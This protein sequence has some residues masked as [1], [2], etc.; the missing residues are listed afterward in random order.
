MGTNLP[1]PTRGVRDVVSAFADEVEGSLENISIFGVHMTRKVTLSIFGLFAIVCISIGVALGVD[2]SSSNSRDGVNHSAF[3]KE[4]RYWSLGATIESSLGK[5]IYDNTTHEHETLVWLAD[6]DPMRLDITSSMEEILQRFVVANFYFAT[7]GAEWNDQL[8]FVSKKSVCDW[9]DKTSGVFCNDNN[10][11]SKILLPQCNLNG[12]IPHDIGVLSHMEI[13]NLTKNDLQGTIPISFGVMSSLT[14]V[15]LSLNGL[16]GGIPLSIAM[17]LD[18]VFLDLSFNSLEGSD[19]VSALADLP[20][21]EEIHLSYNLLTGKI[22]QFGNSESLRIFDISHNLITGQIPRRFGDGKKLEYV[23]LNN[24]QIRGELSNLIGQMKSLVELDISDNKLS[25]SL[26][27]ALGDLSMLQILKLNSNEL[28]YGLPVELGYLDEL[29]VLEISDNGIESI[30]SELF[31]LSNLQKLSLSFNHISGSLPSEI[32]LAISLGELD[33]S[34]NKIS[35]K[36]PPEV[37]SLSALVYLYLNDNLFDGSIPSDLSNLYLLK[38]MDISNNYF[39]GNMESQFCE[40]RPDWGNSIVRY[41][42]DCLTGDI[43]FPCATECCDGKSHCC[44]SGQIDCKIQDY[45][46]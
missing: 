42:A 44:I 29:R 18:L 25:G 32:G 27:S 5:D 41:K 26:P 15:D 7:N 14:S 3:R 39:F 23:K 16:S 24:N 45:E 30:P 36:L 33:L 28:Q 19:D 13:F 1:E 46:N 8:N 21:L 4:H 12:T 2:F 34:N 38:E 35:G 20:S 10:Q 9:N 11:V 37:S 17:L 31:N 40:D 22:G 6:S 43:S